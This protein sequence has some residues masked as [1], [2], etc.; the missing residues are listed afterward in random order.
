MGEMINCQGII[1]L[2]KINNINKK[3]LKNS[4]SFSLKVIKY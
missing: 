4:I 2:K 3:K 1:K